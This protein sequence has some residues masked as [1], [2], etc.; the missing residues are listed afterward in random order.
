MPNIVIA[1]YSI[2]NPGRYAT[3]QKFSKINLDRL[4]NSPGKFTRL[5]AFTIYLRII[6]TSYSID[7]GVLLDDVVF[8][9][10]VN[11][12][13]RRCRKPGGLELNVS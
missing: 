1:N 10:S 9:R 11:K 2:P 7:A 13:E 4:T 3:T 6:G 5:S 12:D 8:T